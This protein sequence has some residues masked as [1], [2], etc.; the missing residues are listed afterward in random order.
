MQNISNMQT[1]P[2]TSEPEFLTAEEVGARLRLPLST[3][4]HLAKSG[5]LPAM[6]L[7]RS[8]RFP[9]LEIKQL[10]TRK[11][12][13]ARIL[14]VDDDEV[15]RTFVT[16]VLAPRGCLVAEA[17]NVRDGLTE[18][19]RQRFDLLLVDL[20][21]PGGDGT[22][23]IQELKIEYSLSQMVLI[24]AFP[25]LAQM[26]DPLDLGALTLLRKPLAAHQ[27]VDCAER[28]LGRALPE[29]AGRKA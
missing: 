22:E 25:D 13:G 6:Q 4:Y 29:V 18:A 23:L 12:G 28:I 24:T 5:V 8:W 2:M 16:G 14:V 20:K 7:G 3:V 27:L 19:R 11:Q 17:S 15:T 9:S 10:A 21:M 1:E 26:K